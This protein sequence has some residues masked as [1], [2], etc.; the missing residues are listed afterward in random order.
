MPLYSF[1]KLENDL[2]LGIWKINESES[3]LLQVLEGYN[4]DELTKI[5]HASKRIEWLSSRALLRIIQTKL[6]KKEYLLLKTAS[7]KPFLQ[8]LD[9]WDISISHSNT[10][11]AIALVKNKRV[12]LDIQKPDYKLLKIGKKYLNAKEMKV[13]QENLELH[14]LYW[15]SKEA[16]YK[17]IGLKGISFKDQIEVD[18]SNKSKIKAKVNLEGETI[19]FRLLL[20]KVENYDIVLAI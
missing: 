1:S 8:D 9:D 18:T 19:D 3:C 12:G 15:S 6:F 17:N 7:S 4:L 14:N 13:C 5:T 2:F 11:V 16:I 20:L 10:F